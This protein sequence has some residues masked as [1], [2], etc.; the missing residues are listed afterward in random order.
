[1]VVSED[2]IR[3]LVAEEEVGV[4]LAP[5][6]VNVL[7][8]KVDQPPPTFSDLVANMPTFLLAFQING[9]ESGLNDL[10][11]FARKLGLSAAWLQGLSHG[12]RRLTPIES[13]NLG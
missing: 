4:G 7:G 5:C 11:G 9:I 13:T 8:I 3:G 1:M 6:F 10:L 12:W 2:L